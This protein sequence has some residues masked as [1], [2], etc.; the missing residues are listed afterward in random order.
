MLKWFEDEDVVEQIPKAIGDRL[1]SRSEETSEVSE[2][3]KE[4]KEEQVPMVVEGEV[5]NKT[6]AGGNEGR[7]ADGWWSLSKRITKNL[8]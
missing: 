8:M 6:A 4:N 1:F 3:P 7:L 5:N 2:L